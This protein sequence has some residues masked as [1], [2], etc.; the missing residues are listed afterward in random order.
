MDIIEVVSDV[1]EVIRLHNQFFSPLW[2]K[3]SDVDDQVR[4]AKP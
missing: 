4:M 2:G 1:E 3:I